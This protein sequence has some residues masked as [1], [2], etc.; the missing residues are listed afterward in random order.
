MK[1]RIFS[2]IILLL[3]ALSG[4]S[5]QDQTHYLGYITGY[6][7]YLS[8]SVSGNLIHCFVHR[9][10]Q[11]QKGQTLYVLDP[12]PQ[13]SQIEQAQAEL[14]RSNQNLSNLV[15]GQRNTIIQEITAQQRQAEAN[16]VLA[17]QQLQR[18]QQ[19]YKMGAVG[20]AELDI[21]VAEYQ[22]NQER[23]KQLAA[24]LAEAKLGA[25]KHI[26]SAQEATVEASY[27]KIRELQ[28]ELAQ[29]TVHANKAGMIFDTFYRTGEFVPAGQ[30][31]LALL[32]PQNIRVQFFVPEKILGALKIG[33]SLHF[34]C[35]HC[36]T[37]GV[38]IIYYISPQAEYTPPI[39]YSRDT[40]EKLVYRI[41]AYIKPA[42]AVRF[43]I[44][45]PIEVL[46]Q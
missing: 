23:V 7:V 18:Y 38:A 27:A 35:D 8:S 25:R 17:R 1:K 39:I 46:L 11:V 16:L 12:N 5:G 15:T 10:E 28:W 13:Q 44:G 21:R 41:E 31:V 26:I 20:K 2:L 37:P 40:R 32:P 22:T 3:V 34:T 9:G 4:C 14:Q 33:Q 30:A 24:T 42:E 29:K 45:Q 43:H 19:L 6:Y 36:K